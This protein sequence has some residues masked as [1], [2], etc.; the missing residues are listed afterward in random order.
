M[1][2]TYHDHTANLG[3]FPRPGLPRRP[4]AENTH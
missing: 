2:D 1:T 3:F 4:N